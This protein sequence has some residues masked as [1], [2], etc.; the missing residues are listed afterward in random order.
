MLNCKEATRLLSESQERPLSLRE[1]LVLNMH[2]IICSGCR[3]FG[4][5]MDI[6]RVAAKTFANRGENSK[7]DD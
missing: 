4:K 7:D 2:T 1:K 3:N 6:L 5:H